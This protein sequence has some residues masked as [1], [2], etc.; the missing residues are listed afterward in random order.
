V[1]KLVNVAV[2]SGADARVSPDLGRFAPKP[3]SRLSARVARPPLPPKSF[4][5]TNLT[6]CSVVLFRGR[7]PTQF[8]TFLTQGRPRPCDATIASALCATVWALR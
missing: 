1:I 7:Q 4:P 3:D 2:G 5:G 6:L 8:G